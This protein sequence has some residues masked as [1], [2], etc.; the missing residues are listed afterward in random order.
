M[1]IK[2]AIAAITYFIV[3]TTRIK[4]IRDWGITAKGMRIFFFIT[5]FTFVNMVAV[6]INS[7]EC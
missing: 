5:A 6:S 7:I 4:R 3:V 1:F 2:F